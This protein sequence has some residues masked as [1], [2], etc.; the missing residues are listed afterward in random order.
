M[1]EYTPFFD[2]DVKQSFYRVRQIVMEIQNIIDRSPPEVVGANSIE[3]QLALFVYAAS[4][5]VKNTVLL[6]RLIFTDDPAEDYARTYVIGAAAFQA[7][8]KEAARLAAEFSSHA[9]PASRN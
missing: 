9:P 4:V 2:E 6:E 7:A 1:P 5:A 8:T 3:N